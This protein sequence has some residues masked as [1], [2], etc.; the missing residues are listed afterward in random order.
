MSEDGYGTLG[1]R[2]IPSP[3]T[4]SHDSRR[5]MEIANCR[6]L[7][8][9]ASEFH[10]A[11]CQRSAGQRLRFFSKTERAAFDAACRRLSRAFQEGVIS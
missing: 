5:R 1:L 8:Q 9:L 4:Q 7:L 10:T 3:G 6:L 2:G 11:V